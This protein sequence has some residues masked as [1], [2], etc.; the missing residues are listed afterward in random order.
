MAERFSKGDW[1]NH[2]CEVWMGD[3]YIGDVR[4]EHSDNFI[5]LLNALADENSSLKR[6][7]D[8]LVESIR[9]TAKMTADAITKPLEKRWD[10][11]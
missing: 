9:E 2:H 1:N 3:E 6:Q 4:T 8:E 11:F 10:A 5:D 7:R